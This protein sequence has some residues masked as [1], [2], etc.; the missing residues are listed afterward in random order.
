M[1]PQVA[2]PSPA[3]QTSQ[4][5]IELLQFQRKLQRCQSLRDAL[6]VSVNDSFSVFRFHQAILWQYDFRRHINISAVSGL[7]ETPENSPYAQWLVEVIDWLMVNRPKPISALAF[8]E[9]PESLAEDGEEWLHE[10][11]LHCQLKGPEGNVVGGL[12]FHRAEAFNETETA[13]AQWVTDAVGYTLWG[14][15]RDRTQLEKIMKRRSSKVALLG[16]LLVVGVLSFVP[17]RLSALAPA[18]ISPVRPI[19]ITSP[20]EGVVGRIVVKPN[21]EVKVDQVLVE[22]DDTNLRNRLAVAA[23]ALDTARADYQ[24]AANKAFSDEGS[25]SELLLLEAKARERA[26]EVA[27]LSDLLTRLRITAPQGGIA[28]FSDAEDWRGKP[29]QPGER[30]MTIANPARIGVTVYLPPQD[31]V[32]LNVGGEVTLFLDTDPLSPIKAQIV[33]TSYEASVMPDNTLAYIVK[34]S[35]PLDAGFPRIGLRGTAKV[36]GEKVSLGYYLLRKPILFVRRSLGL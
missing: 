15:R 20:V 16:V 31:A 29:V 2:Q 9:L 35:L 32:Q 13:L 33:Q 30:I 7:A 19:P 21:E 8:E 34:G 4:P 11:I 18:E 3:A 26:A 27:Y 1:A 23:K 14:W 25:K 22:L 28:V 10:N 36:Y 24:R 12:L 6:F 5:A 17:V